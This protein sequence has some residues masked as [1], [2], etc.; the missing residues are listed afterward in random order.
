[1]MRP[2]TTGAFVRVLCCEGGRGE[3]VRQLT[4]AAEA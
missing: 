3:G 2:K 4:V 1:M